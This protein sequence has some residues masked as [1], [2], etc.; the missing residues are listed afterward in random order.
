VKNRCF[1][2]IDA[3]HIFTVFYANSLCNFRSWSL[4]PAKA[5]LRKRAS[6]QRKSGKPYDLLIWFPR[7]VVSVGTWF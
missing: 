6:I 3:A 4:V 5:S 2:Q 1:F 7:Q